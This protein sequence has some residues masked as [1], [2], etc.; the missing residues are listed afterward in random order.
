MVTLVFVIAKLTGA[1]DWSWLVVYSPV[2]IYMALGAV[3]TI[4]ILLAVGVGILIGFKK[5]K[6]FLKSQG[7]TEY[8]DSQHEFIDTGCASVMTDGTSQ[9]ESKKVKLYEEQGET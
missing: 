8:A 9:A 6:N 3:I 1:I 7:S 2:L 5:L 4:F